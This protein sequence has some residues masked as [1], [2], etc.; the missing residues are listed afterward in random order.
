MRGVFRGSTQTPGTGGTQDSFPGD[1]LSAVFG[2]G[3]GRDG[4]AWLQGTASKFQ[5]QPRN[6]AGD[7]GER[8]P[9]RPPAG[10]HLPHRHAGR[11][12]RRQRPRPV[13]GA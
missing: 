4:V 13:G 1:R 10:L 7:L 6:P 9:V 8:R 3:R 11:P 5:V 2:G 12:G